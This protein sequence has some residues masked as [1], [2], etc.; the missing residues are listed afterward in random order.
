M[1][2]DPA[3]RCPRVTSEAATPPYENLSGLPSST[4]TIQRIGR[5]K[6]A[7]ANPVQVIVFG[8]YKS[9]QN[10]RKDVGQEVFSGPAPL[11]IL[12][13]QILPFGSLHKIDFVQR[14]TLP[15]FPRNSTA[16]V[17]ARR[18]RWQS[19]GFWRPGHFAYE[20]GLAILAESFAQSVRRRRRQN[21]LPGSPAIRFSAAVA[22]RGPPSS[23]F[24]PGERTSRVSLRSPLR[25]VNSIY[26]SDA[27]FRARISYRPMGLTFFAGLM[28]APRP[29]RP[30]SLSR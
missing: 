10:A 11:D 4:A 8:Q 15:T 21:R 22:F 14:D 7:P 29:C 20:I 25:T 26:F 3:K 1:V 28:H 16:H 30:G 5:I 12:R 13:G 17:S 6:R 18:P 9:W 23:G 24:G 2:A 27:R 19:H